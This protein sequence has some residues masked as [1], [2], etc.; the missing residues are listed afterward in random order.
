MKVKGQDLE[1]VKPLSLIVSIDLSS[2]NFSGEFSTEI[3]KLSGL[4]ILNLSRNHLNGSIPE[5]M[6]VLYELSSLDLSGNNLEGIIP[7]STSSFTFLS[8]LNLSNNFS[9]KIPLP[10]QMTT[11]DESTFARNPHLYGPLLGAYCPSDDLDQGQRQSNVED[12]NDDGFIDQ[13]F[14]LSI[15]IGHFRTIFCFTY[16]KI[17]V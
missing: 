14:Y 1:H 5:S 4:M 17:L 13:W 16:K 3:T 10:G 11:F 9:S 8:Y 2:N 6:S 12:E 15:G 7:S